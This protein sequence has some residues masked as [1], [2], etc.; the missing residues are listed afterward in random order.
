MGRLRRPSSRGG[1]N[2][3]QPARGHRTEIAC[4]GIGI[5]AARRSRHSR[6]LNLT[7]K[8]R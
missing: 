3:R 6:Q 1:H 2:G 4:Y 7:Q 5:L 8:L